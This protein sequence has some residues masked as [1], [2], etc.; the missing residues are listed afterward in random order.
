MLKTNSTKS[1]AA[2]I[3]GHNF[4]S[5]LGLELYSSKQ[6]WKKRGKKDG[7]KL[8]LPNIATDTVLVN[9]YRM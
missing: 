1:A 4:N 9:L 2:T 3:F 8:I 6:I 7:Q 5:S